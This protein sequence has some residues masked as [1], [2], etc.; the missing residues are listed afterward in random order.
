MPELRRARRS[1]TEAA[2]GA[3]RLAAA[4]GSQTQVLGVGLDDN[5][6]SG[7]LCPRQIRSTF[8]WA[9]RYVRPLITPRL[10][11]R[12]VLEGGFELVVQAA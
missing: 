11:S 6:W 9:W 3:D 7:R 1:T 8:V 4:R 2:N 12:Q 5:L 10:I